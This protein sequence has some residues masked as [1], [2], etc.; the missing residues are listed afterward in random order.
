MTLVSNFFKFS[1][2][3]VNNIYWY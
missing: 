3:I 2:F 1:E